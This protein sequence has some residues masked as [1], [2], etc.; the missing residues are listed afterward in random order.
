MPRRIES[1]EQ[2]IQFLFGRINYEQITADSLSARDFKLERMRRL[3]DLLGNP[4][5]AIPAV[6][7]AG[8]KG[9]GSTAAMVAAILSA[10]GLRAGLFTSPHMD[11]FEERLTINGRPPAAEEL[12]ELLNVVAEAV[13]AMEHGPRVER[14]TF[15]E[16]ATALGWLYFAAQRAD[17]AVLEVGLG[18]RL[19]STNICRPEVTVVT[20]ISRDH[21]AV[22]G[23]ELSQIAAEKAGIVK[24]GVPVVSGVLHPEARPVVAA[25]AA[26]QAAPLI[27][28]GRDLQ[29]RYAPLRFEARAGAGLAG[30]VD[31]QTA[32]NRWDGIPLT[33]AGEHQAANAALATA[34][35]DQLIQR[36]WKIP[37]QA[38]W[39]GMS[40]VRWPLRF[41]ILSERPLFVVDAAHNPA[42]MDAVC[43]TLESVF[44]GR[45]RT[46][47]F[48]ATKD[49]DVAG[50]LE[51][52]VGLFAH[53]VLTQY[54]N[55]P[56]AMPLDELR[57]IADS[58]RMLDCHMAADP[59]EAWQ[60]AV[61]L[62]ESEDV[63]CGTGSSF[64]AAELRSLVLAQTRAAVASPVSV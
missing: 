43:R 15:F 11:V 17:I 44:P 12:V 58:L 16:V 64:I 62:S 5:N 27:Q 29:F 26:A 9:K 21:T 4:Q 32:G 40:L 23:N 45:R 13:T 18:G 35:I 20:N 59:A 38:V 41:E 54:R 60:T 2:A 22:L 48:G 63:I 49:K 42:S 56:R 36:G 10:A 61:R 53:V 50:M 52:L 37:T 28:L 1:Y 7:I 14:P 55:N 31:V 46:L 51:R 30:R 3:L 39:T 24:A 33:L 8:T 25:A 6:H 19:D 57:G 34:V 47:I